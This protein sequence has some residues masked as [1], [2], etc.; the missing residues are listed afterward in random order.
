MLDDVGCDS[1]G[2]CDYMIDAEITQTRQGGGWL[3]SIM[4][5][6]IVERTKHAWPG[7]VQSTN[8]DGGKLG[9]HAVC[10]DER[11]SLATNKLGEAPGRDRIQ[12]AVAL[13][14]N[15]PH[16]E[17]LEVSNHRSRVVRALLEVRQ[18]GLVASAI[19]AT[20]QGEHVCLAPSDRAGRGKV[21]DLC[22]G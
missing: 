4:V 1:I 5:V 17:G 8:H 19:E 22:S 2:D 9:S 15:R 21:Q 10:V 16:S 6:S 11:K 14:V 7:G 3:V 18:P 20:Q 12:L 13:Q